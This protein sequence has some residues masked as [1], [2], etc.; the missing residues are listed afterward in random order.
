MK[1][2]I[3]SAKHKTSPKKYIQ[4]S[5]NEILTPRFIYDNSQTIPDM[6]AAE[7]LSNWLYEQGYT[8]GYSSED[9][10]LKHYGCTFDRLYDRYEKDMLRR[11]YG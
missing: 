10:F 1:R 6:K 9:E 4:S 5:W 7:D 2:Y 3:K 11:R 8:S